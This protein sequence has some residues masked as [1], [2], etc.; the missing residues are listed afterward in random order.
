M[1]EKP[2]G[3]LCFVTSYFEML[4]FFTA[5]TCLSVCW[6][7]CSISCIKS[8]QSCYYMLGWCVRKLSLSRPHPLQMPADQHWYKTGRQSNQMT[9]ETLPFTAILAFPPLL[10]FHT[11]LDTMLPSPFSLPTL[12]VPLNSL[13]WAW[14]ISVSIFSKY[15][16]LVFL[17]FSQVEQLH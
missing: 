10:I 16:T 8:L 5:H 14:K 13:H 7:I 15:V 2:F 1:W 9:D 12:L 11:Y 3:F 6:P 17:F 4:Q